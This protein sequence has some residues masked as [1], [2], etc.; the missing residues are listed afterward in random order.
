MKTL[1]LPKDKS[2]M[3]RVIDFFVNLLINTYFDYV[4]VLVNK[5]KTGL[6][7]ML[8]YSYILQMTRV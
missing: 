3:Y 6:N 2:S 1:Q 8:N 4:Y 7:F 5:L